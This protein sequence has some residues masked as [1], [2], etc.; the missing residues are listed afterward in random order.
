ML[1][2]QLGLPVFFYFVT[3]LRLKEKEV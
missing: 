2:G 1:I 3:W